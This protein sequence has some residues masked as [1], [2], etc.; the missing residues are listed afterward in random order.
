M[1][2]EHELLWWLIHPFS[3]NRCPQRWPLPV[4]SC[5]LLKQDCGGHAILALCREEIVGGGSSHCT[6]EE[7]TQGGYLPYSSLLRTRV[8]RSQVSSITN[9]AQRA[10]QNH[11]MAEYIWLKTVQHTRLPTSWLGLRKSQAGFK[12]LFSQL[13]S[14]ALKL[15]GK[16]QMETD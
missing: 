8:P 5:L 4:S 14:N 15:T 16:C 7:D 12:N 13:E 6:Q 1:T 3:R 2:H 9:Q 10:L 11:L